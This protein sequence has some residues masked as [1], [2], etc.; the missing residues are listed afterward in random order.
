MK[1]SRHSP[2][3]T[4]HS[5]TAYLGLGSNLGDRRALINSALD[6][7]NKS[8]H[9]NVTKVSTL[10]ETTPVGGPPGQNNYLNAAAQITTTFSAEQLLL[11]L[12]SIETRLG[13]EP[14]ETRAHWAPRPI[15]LD[16]ILFASEIID[17]PHLQVPHPLLHR[18]RFVLEPLA[19]I[20]P[21]LIHPTL[22]LPIRTLL[23]EL[24]LP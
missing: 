7:L 6:L 2:L 21:D 13:R 12:Q 9:I 11:F 17:L 18:R 3:T 16:L 23:A 14:L 22:G 10:I 5:F 8:D 19:Q 15:D 20:A 1:N 24:P 4:H